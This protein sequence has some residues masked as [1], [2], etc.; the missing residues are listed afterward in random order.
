M[1]LKLV[2]LCMNLLI[3]KLF[4]ELILKSMKFWAKFS[5]IVHELSPINKKLIKKRED[6]QKKI[7]ELAQIK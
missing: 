4:Q 7:D 5:K 2:Q 6:I 1:G 3:M